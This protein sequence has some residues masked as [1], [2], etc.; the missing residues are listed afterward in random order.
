MRFQSWLQELNS[1]LP[2]HLVQ[3]ESFPS[4]WAEAFRE[5][6][7]VA[8]ILSLLK[9]QEEDMDPSESQK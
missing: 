6:C 8:W 2:V 9:C 4:T 3:S 1:S 7:L 5:A